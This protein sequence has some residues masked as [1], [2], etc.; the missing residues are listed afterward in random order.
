[1]MLEWKFGLGTGVIV[2]MGAPYL[3]NEDLILM[4]SRLLLA[5]AVSRYYESLWMMIC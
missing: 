4:L 5:R 3:L 1:M 2:F